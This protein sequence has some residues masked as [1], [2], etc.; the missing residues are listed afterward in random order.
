MDLLSSSRHRVIDTHGAVR[1]VLV[2][3]DRM[4]DGTG[5]AICTV[6]YVID[7]TAQLDENRNETIH[8]ALSE[9]AEARAAIE[10]ARGVLMF[11]YG[12]TAEQAF[13]VLR[14]CSMETNT[15]IHTLAHEIVTAVTAGQGAPVVVRT[16][17]DHA[18][19]TAHELPDPPAGS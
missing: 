2:G 11:V 1:R 15:K 12:I 16:R 17:V 3:G 8:G 9:I 6:G 4:F 14:W 18:L 19:L 5:A 10:Q 13:G 7:R